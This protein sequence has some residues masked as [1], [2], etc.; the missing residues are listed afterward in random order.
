KMLIII[1]SL[2]ISVATAE[3][4]F[5]TLRRLKTWLRSTIGEERLNGLALLHIHKDI[6][7]DIENIITRFAEQKK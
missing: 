2:P 3:R 4:S 7:I 1:C 5:S 6:P